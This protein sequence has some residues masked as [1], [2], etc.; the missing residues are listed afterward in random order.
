MMLI[1]IEANSSGGHDNQSSVP[2]VIPSGWAVVP[3]NIVIPETFP[4]VNLEV[5]G[6][7]VTAMTAGIIPEPEPQPEPEPT[8]EER[9][10]M[11]ETNKAEQR[12]LD[13]LSA[14]IERG[15]SL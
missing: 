10:E 15:L 3:D 13:A 11:L 1:K 9:L 7:L 2:K 5:E 8:L 6:D 4:F 12:D 14:A